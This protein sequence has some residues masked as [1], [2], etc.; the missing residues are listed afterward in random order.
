[1]ANYRKNYLNQVIF[2]INFVQLDVLKLNID[3]NLS[4]LCCQI[5]NTELSKAPHVNVSI[6]PDNKVISETISSFQ[7]NGSSIRILIQDSILQIIAFQYE[8][9]GH[10]HKII[11]QIT[12]M[13]IQKYKPKIIRAAIRYVNNII[14]ESGSTY[15]FNKMINENLLRSTNYFVEGGFILARS[16]GNMFIKNENDVEINFVYGYANPEFPNKISKGEFL[17]DYDCSKSLSTEDNVNVSSTIA[18]I[19]QF[20]NIIFE[21]SITEVL[22][23]QMRS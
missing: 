2:Q 17:L 16:I 23:I 21:K 12:T 15:D 4:D 10:F 9:H 19:K 1:M 3:K 18:E 22:K 6:L 11:D 8:N 14:S 5:A 20:A 13:F 7:F